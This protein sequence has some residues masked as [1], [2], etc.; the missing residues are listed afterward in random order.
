MPPVSHDEAGIVAGSDTHSFDERTLVDHGS[1]GEDSSRHGRPSTE[2]SDG[3]HDLLESEDERERLL[4]Q[5]DGLFSKQS[6]KIGRRKR[7]K[8]KKKRQRKAAGSEDTSALM[9]EM[10]EGIGASSS[11]ISRHSSESD[12]QRLIATS[13]HRKACPVTIF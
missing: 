6:V 1:D 2:I 9:Y 12:E 13:T 10:E 3:E 5:K 11:S 4:T 8:A 7:E